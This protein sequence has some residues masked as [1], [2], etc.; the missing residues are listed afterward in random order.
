[1]YIFS[2]LS[3]TDF[4]HFR[5]RLVSLT[6]VKY[7]NLMVPTL[8]KMRKIGA[9]FWACQFFILIPFP[10]FGNVFLPQQGN[11][12]TTIAVSVCIC[13][14]SHACVPTLTSLK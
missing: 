1:M 10:A 8:A 12:S 5:P 14:L 9:I 7:L 13:W 2:Y 11:L 3:A 4:I 6:D